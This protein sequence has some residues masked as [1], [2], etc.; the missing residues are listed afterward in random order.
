[1]EKFLEALSSDPKLQEKA[2]AQTTPEGLFELAKP[3]LDGMNEEDFINE[4]AAAAE[5]ITDRPSGELS[6]DELEEVSGGISPFLIT[7]PIML[8]IQ[9]WRGKKDKKEKAAVVDQIVDMQAQID[10]LQAQQG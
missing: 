6:D 8:G 2:K 7:M 10:E 5:K 4:L 1:M 9:W 3:Y